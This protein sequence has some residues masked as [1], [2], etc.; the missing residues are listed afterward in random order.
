MAKKNQPKF[1][2]THW[3]HN[4]KSEMKMENWLTMEILLVQN[5]KCH[6]SEKIKLKLKETWTLEISTETIQAPRVWALSTLEKEDR[7]DKLETTMMSLDRSQEVWSEELKFQL[8][9]NKESLLHSTQIIR[10][11]ELQSWLIMTHMV[12]LD[13]LWAKQICRREWANQLKVKSRA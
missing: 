2:T 7:F 6:I 10:F 5:L 3:N 13:A 4:L 12:K 1:L 11:Q 8:D 9:K